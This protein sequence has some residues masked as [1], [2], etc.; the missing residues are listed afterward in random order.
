MSTSPRVEIGHRKE[1][2]PVQ[3]IFCLKDK[4]QGKINSHRWLFNAFGPVL[5]PNICVL[6]DVGVTPGPGSIFR[7]WKCFD[8]D[9]NVG[10]AEGELVVRKGAFGFNILNPLVAA[11]NFEYKMNSVLK[12]PIESV[13]GYIPVLSGAFCAYRLVFL[14]SWDQLTQVEMSNYQIFCASE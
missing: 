1:Q 6:I 9:R 7:L 8:D 11:Q 12:K 13:L 5:N 14:S 4:H 10:G 2:V 3:L